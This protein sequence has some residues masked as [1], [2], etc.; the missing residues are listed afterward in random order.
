MRTQFLATLVGLLLLV[1]PAFG[2][3]M[4][5]GNVILPVLESSYTPNPVVSLMGGSYANDGSSASAVGVELSLDCPLYQPARGNVRQQISYMNVALTGAD[6][7]LIEL[8]PHWMSTMG[9][10]LSVGF[11][12]GLGIAQTSVTGGA[13]SSKF[14]VGFGVSASY[15]MDSLQL[16]AEYRTMNGSRTALKAGV[17]F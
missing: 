17:A 9:Q 4:E 8:N 11:G 13:S 1:S 3:T 7:T 5:S 10:F 16:G 12:P 14:S 6:V 2:E 15:K